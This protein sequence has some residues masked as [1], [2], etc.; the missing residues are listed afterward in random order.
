MCTAHC[1]PGLI[2]AAA[3]NGVFAYLIKPARVAD[4][5]ASMQV[6]VSRFQEA[7]HL[8]QEVDKLKGDL[9]A[10]KIIEKAKGIIMRM[11]NMTEEDAHRFLQKESQ[12][13]SK[14]LP[15]L[16]QAIITAEQI[17]QS[18]CLNKAPRE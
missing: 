14:P 1:D 7:R 16:A 17:I 15:E 2:D 12:R 5:L 6:A 13:Q 11:H 4:M 3:A 8:C 10:R 18:E 9:N